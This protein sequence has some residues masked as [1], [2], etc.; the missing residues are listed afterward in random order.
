MNTDHMTFEQYRTATMLTTG[1]FVNAVFAHCHYHATYAGKLTVR[2]SDPDSCFGSL[3][4]PEFIPAG[5][6]VWNSGVK[7]A[8]PSAI[9]LERS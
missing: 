7:L 9:Q 3:D 1:G 2:I 4:R 8:Y 6:T 5:S